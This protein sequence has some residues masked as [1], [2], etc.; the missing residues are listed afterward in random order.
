MSRR[1]W[2]QAEIDEWKL[3]QRYPDT[4]LP[5][6]KYDVYSPYADIREKERFRSKRDNI[7]SSFIEWIL[8][9]LGVGGFILF[10]LYEIVTMSTGVNG[11][12]FIILLISMLILT[13]ITSGKKRK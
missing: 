10:M 8:I 2:T 4:P 13:F 6:P 9:I 3:H 11:D 7:I 1:I 12:K 5:K